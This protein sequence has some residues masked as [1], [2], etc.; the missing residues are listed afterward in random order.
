[1]PI[2]LIDKIKQKNNGT[3]KLVDASDINWDTNVPSDKVPA[4]YVKKDAMNT[5]I[6]QAVAAAP[7]LKRV[8]LAKGSTLP[9]VGEDN[10]IYMLPDLTESQNEYTEYF[11]INGKFEK[12]GGSKTD[13]TNYPSRNDMDTAINAAKNAASTDAQNKA[14][15][16]LTDAKAYTDQEKAKYLPLAGGTLSGKVKYAANQS[17]SDNN[18]LVTKAYVDAKVTGVKPDDMLTPSQITTGTVNGAIQVKDK[19]VQVF[20]LKSAAYHEDTDFLT[21]SDLTWNSIA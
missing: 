14:N 19:N 3:F 10:T 21:P 18:D 4:D 5:A 12:L 2:Q 16:A 7:H 1:M 8:V 20:G 13:L 6:A 15:K 17:I 11:W 9:A